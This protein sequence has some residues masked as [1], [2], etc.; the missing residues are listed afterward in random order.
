MSADEVAAEPQL[1]RPP[2]AQRAD[3]LPDRD[4]PRRAAKR[5]VDAGAGARQRDHEHLHKE[6]GDAPCE[7]GEQRAEAVE[8]ED[9]VEELHQPRRRPGVAYEKIQ[10]RHLA[11]VLV[12]LGLLLVAERVGAIAKHLAVRH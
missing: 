4:V 7:R 10:V 8:E 9:Q 12:Q 2:G 11:R 6:D 3:E 1:V 5:G